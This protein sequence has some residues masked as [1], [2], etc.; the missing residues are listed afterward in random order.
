[1]IAS[2]L[3]TLA[4]HCCCVEPW[5]PCDLMLYRVTTDSMA[6]YCR[7]YN[8]TGPRLRDRDIFGKQQNLELWRQ[9]TGGKVSMEMMEKLVYGQALENLKNIPL[10]DEAIAYLRTA[11]SIERVRKKLID[12]WYFPNSRN[13]AGE[14]SGMLTELLDECLRHTSGKLGH[15]YTLLALRCYNALRRYTEAV[16]FW[17]RQQKRMPRNII[18]DMAEREAAA[19][20]KGTGERR[21]AANI[22]G[23]LGDIRSL[24]FVREFDFD[25]M[26]YVYERCPNSPYFVEEIQ[27][28]LTH[29]DNHLTTRD[30]YRWTEKDKKRR[31]TFIRLGK[32]VLRENRVQDRALWYY[33]V[34]AM[35]DSKECPQ[36]ALQYV[37]QGEKVC[38]TDKMKRYMRVLRIYCEAR[39]AV[40]D[41][42]YE[43]QLLTDLKWLRNWGL[44]EMNKQRKRCRKEPLPWMPGYEWW[45]ESQYW[46]DA[47][48]RILLDA[49]VPSMMKQGKTT[50]ALQLANYAEYWVHRYYSTKNVILEQKGVPE[51]D[52]WDDFTY[53]NEVFGLADNLPAD[54]V[55]HYFEWTQTHHD[56][57]DR[58]VTAGSRQDTALW[59][60]IIGTHYLR[61]RKYQQAIHWLSML[62]RGNERWM[63][64]R[65]YM[66]FDPFDLAI[67]GS[68]TRRQRVKSILNYKLTYAQRMATYERQMQTGRNSNERAKAQ[69][70]FA[71]G[72]YNAWDVCWPLTMYANS[73]SRTRGYEFESMTWKVD[74]EKKR[75]MNMIDQGL[76]KMDREMRGTF[77]YA[78]ERNRRVMQECDGTSTA[79]FLRLHCD[80]WK[81]YGK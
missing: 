59:A 45:P 58:F 37:R 11:K 34:A 10:S 64:V 28:L 62:P 20:Y 25:E 3:A 79:Q 50:R 57:L 30:S 21:K 2:L 52:M 16:T 63:N 51:K 49:V 56:A 24:R 41:R 9:E 14:H 47:M 23:R 44:E 19:A 42:Q 17:E 78:L 27:C 77:L 39:T 4:G 40:M 48:Q 18:Y 80:T 73:W 53:C 76:A 15:R 38:K 67:E 8:Y 36:E 70:M 6:M 68:R 69:V 1:M 66:T 46:R 65:E 55:A 43:S 61:E 32:R 81:D 33:A 72:W 12:P 5:L 60:D 75:A 35:L 54:D 26:E 31:E 71:V 29:F 13:G 7:Q 22:Y 74:G